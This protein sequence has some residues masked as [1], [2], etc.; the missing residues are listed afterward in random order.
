[1]AWL[2]VPWTT[3]PGTSSSGFTLIATGWGAR[4]SSGQLGV[5]LLIPLVAL[6]AW[7][8]RWPVAALFRYRTLLLK[9]QTASDTRVQ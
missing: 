8:Q 4:A 1:M 5:L 2:V 6:S 7:Y 9:C 3:F